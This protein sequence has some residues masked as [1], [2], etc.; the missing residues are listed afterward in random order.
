MVDEVNGEQ[1]SVDEKDYVPFKD[2]FKRK[3]AKDAKNY[4]PGPGGSFD[5][6]S[7]NKILLDKIKGNADSKALP[8]DKLAKRR[9]DELHQL[10]Y[11]NTRYSEALFNKEFTQA[12]LLDGEVLRH[13]MKSVATE[14]MSGI[15]NGRDFINAIRQNSDNG[16]PVKIK[17][18]QSGFVVEVANISATDTFRLASK[19]RFSR[20]D[21]GTRTNGMMFSIEDGNIECEIVDW[22]LDHVVDCNIEGWTKEI[23]GDLLRI[24]DTTHLKSMTLYA[25]YPHGVAIQQECQNI[26]KDGKKCTHTN[27]VDRSEDSDTLDF[28]RA[29]VVIPGH[30]NL[31]ARRFLMRDSVTVD[32]VKTYQSD[33]MD[34]NKVKTLV[35]P[36][37]DSGKQSIYLR[38]KIAG[39][40]DFRSV[41]KTYIANLESIVDEIMMSST[42]YTEDAQMQE[43]ATIINEYRRNMGGESIAPWVKE[44]VLRTPDNDG[45]FNDVITNEL[46]TILGT[47]R[48][49][50]IDSDMRTRMRDLLVDFQINTVYTY[51]GLTSYTCPSCKAKQPNVDEK[52]DMIP[53]PVNMYFLLLMVLRHSS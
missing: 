53:I 9:I 44:V 26:D 28:M 43:R 11:D 16:R 20:D 32:E 14:A 27:K 30:F 51:F 22:I 47:L 17:C 50:S 45:G 24:P 36:L 5:Y 4:L 2:P 13:T 25:M 31:R 40:N 23:I 46:S 8:E 52:H 42:S 12:L 37:N 19:I 41:I 1:P 33:L 29:S 49:L 15:V 21:I 48:E 18:W 35:G 34:D 10:A 6:P 39:Y 7:A 38:M 3:A